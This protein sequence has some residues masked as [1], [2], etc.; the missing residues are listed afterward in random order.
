MT[1]PRSKFTAV[2]DFSF[3]GVHFATGDVVDGLPLEVALT[4]GDTFVKA[5]TA[6]TR[7]ASTADADSTTEDEE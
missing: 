5:D 4:H 3:G 1:K 6:R 2:R 7:K